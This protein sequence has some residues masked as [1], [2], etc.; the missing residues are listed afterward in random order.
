LNQAVDNYCERLGPEFWAEP[1]NAVSNLAFIIAA[2]LLLL[3][4]P[5][6]RAD[7]FLSLWIGVIGIGS[8]LFHT[9]ATRWALAT[10]SLPIL[11]FIVVYFYLAMRDYL[12]LAIWVSASATIAYVP[13]SFAI[14]W[15]ADPVA[16][17][18]SGY[19]AALLAILAVG[20]ATVGRD[21]KTA[22]RLLI[23]GLVF[24]VSIGFRMADEP[25]C[26]VWPAGTH[27]VWHVLNAVVLY[28]LVI[29]YRGHCDRNASKA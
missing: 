25:S 1:L 13:V 4:R 20:A 28:R 29:V 14:A 5:Q 17:S 15:L 26:G 2:I 12:K 11:V 22:S 7:W 27:F 19:V 24:A 6:S 8:F 21:G 9:F 18:S 23:T 3:S 10:D 16:G